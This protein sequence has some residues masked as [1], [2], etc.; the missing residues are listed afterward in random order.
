MGSA[1]VNGPHDGHDPAAGAELKTGKR[2]LYW[3]DPM[4]PGQR[5][6]K[7]G[8]SPYMD[9]PLIPVYE[10]E[11]ADG[12]AV[13]IDGRVTQNLGVRTAEVKLGRL[14]STERLLV[15]S[16]ALIR[17]GART[18]AMVAKGE[19]GF[20]PVEVK[21]GATAGGQ[22]EILEGLKAG[23]QVVVSGQFLID[24]EASLRGTVARMQETTSGLEV[25][26]Q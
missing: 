24:S 26:F 14:G 5:F 22:S 11:N 2:I 25:L 4:V 19:G 21:A 3:R 7:P 23:Q 10:E 9:M 13:R 6:D 16:E 20:D 12:A 15:P 17:T 8:K 1:T 18:I